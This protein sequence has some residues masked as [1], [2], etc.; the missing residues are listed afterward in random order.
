MWVPIAVWQ[1]CE[2][3]YT[4]YLLTYK[5]DILKTCWQFLIFPSICDQLCNWW[6]SDKKPTGLW[7]HST[8]VHTHYQH[9]S[10]TTDNSM[11][12][13]QIFPT[14]QVH[15]SIILNR[16]LQLL[17]YGSVCITFYI[18]LLFMRVCIVVPHT[19]HISSKSV[20]VWGVGVGVEF[21]APLD[22]V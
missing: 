20:Q 14:Q 2:L 4:C 17:F 21:N 9:L 11:N 6:P 12:R 5:T 13:H 15:K 8:N 7:P 22:T 1:P 18:S 10:L 19:F 3:L 16:A